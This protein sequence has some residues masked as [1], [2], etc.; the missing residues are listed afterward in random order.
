MKLLILAQTPPPL[1]G[2]SAMV[3][4]A[5]TGLPGFGVEL[6]HIDLKLSRSHRDIGG[7]RPGKLLALVDACLHAIAARFTRGCDTLYYVPAP[8]KRGALYRDWVV[9]SLCRPFFPRLVLHYHT[10]GVAEW[11]SGVATAFERALTRKLLGGADVAIVLTDSL[12]R[13]AEFLSPARVRVVPNGIA[14]PG[15]R[16]EPPR[17]PRRRVL[18]LGSGGAEKG[19]LLAAEAVIAAN[20]RHAAPRFE[21]VAAGSIQDGETASRFGA[22]AATAPATLRHVG[23]V[24]GEAL[25]RLW[26]EADCLCLPTHYPHEAQPLV[27]LEALAR[28]VPVVATTWRGIPETVDGSGATLVPPNDADALAEAL[29]ARDAQPPPPQA[30]RAVYLARFTLERHLSQLAAALG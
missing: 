16:R 1:H 7:W 9:M 3:Q 21:L 6:H 13:D 5:V 27:V 24:R 8:G 20:R 30:G 23:F 28:G 11:L 12:R 19:L 22:L 10:G 18:F 14:D 17:G 29:L 25:Q 15:P 2:Q 26:D 4:A